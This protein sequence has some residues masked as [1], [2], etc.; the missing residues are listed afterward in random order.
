M[1]EHEIE[2]ILP[3][4]PSVNRYWRNISVDNCPRTLISEAGRN[5]KREVALIARIETPL[6]GPV[7]VAYFVYRPRRAGD[8]D[9]YLKSL[10]DAL[11]GIAYEDDR[12]VVELHGYLRDD[13]RDPRVNVIIQT[14]GYIKKSAKKHLAVINQPVKHRRVIENRPTLK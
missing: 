1:I 2:L 3:V 13:P 6:T 12:Q 10:L 5:Y 11:T 7:S 14:A 9:N 4:P 8:L